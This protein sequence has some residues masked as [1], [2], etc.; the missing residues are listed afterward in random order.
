MDDIII[1]NAEICDGTGT[2]RRRGDVAVVGGHIAAVGTVAGGARREIDADGLVLTPGFIDLHTHYDCQVSWDRLLTPSCWHGVTSVVMGNCG[3]T[4]APCRPDDRELL[5]RMLLYV[6]GMPT[7]ALTAGIDWQWETF[8]EYLDVVERWRPALNIAAFIGHSAIRY[9]VMG[10]AAA[11]RPA[12]AAEMG[13]MQDLVRDAMRAGACGFSTSES[14]T[15]FFGD[16]TP[17]PS[18][19]APREELRALAA[20]LRE[21]GRGVIEVAPLHLIGDTDSKSADQAFYGELASV[22]GRPV[23]WA[24]LFYNPFDPAGCLRLIEEARVAQDNGV[25]VVPQVGCRPLEVRISFASSTIAT[26]NNPFWRPILHRP[27]DERRALFQSADFRNE[28]RAMSGAGSWVAALAPSWDQMFLR[29]SPSSTHQAWT[30]VPL[31]RIATLRNA[32]PVDTLLDMSLET[33]LACQFGIPIMNTDETTVLKL[34]R[35][36]AGILALSDAGAHVDTLSDQCFTTH[37]LGHWVRE[38]EALSLEEAVRLLTSAPARLYGLSGRGEVRPGFAADL[39]LLDPTT[40]GPQRTELT[41][42]LPGGAARLIQ[43]ARGVE[44]VVVNGEVL[45]DAGRETEARS[46]QVLRG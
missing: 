40:V 9:Y 18:R 16:G 23:T 22:S 19:V 33:D 11:E 14:P 43:R 2:E 30:D 38:L 10:G 3:F 21:A 28:L 17:V 44:Y 20:V 31:S 36:P 27:A 25:R 6:E 34:L 5:M 26:E 37:L 29:W 42:D 12:T 4:I 35:H 45:I 41:S 15:H 8:P 13:R 46:G 24:P 39:V 7:E 1:R 32:D